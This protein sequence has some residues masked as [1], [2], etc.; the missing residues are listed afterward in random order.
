MPSSK[1]S[2]KVVSIQANSRRKRPLSRTAQMQAETLRAAWNHGA[3][4]S[5]DECATIVN[6][7]ANGNSVYDLALI[8]GRSYYSTA[9]ARTHLRFAL[10][11]LEVLRAAWD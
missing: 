4:W 3:E 10:N 1:V 9:T 2:S 6:G 11:H 8:L 5:H 7:I